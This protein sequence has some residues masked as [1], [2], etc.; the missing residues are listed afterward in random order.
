MSDP[1][2]KPVWGVYGGS[3][4]GSSHLRSGLPNQDS[5]GKWADPGGSL[6][7]LAVSDGHGSASHFRSEI[8]SRMGVEAAVQ[9]LRATPIPVPDGHAQVL[10]QSIVQ[11]WREAV[12]AHLA[13]HPFTDGEWGKLPPKESAQA[14][15]AILANPP[16]AYGATLLAV[17]A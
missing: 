13:G 11:A 16:V 1:S 8:G 4:R 3:T 14:K 10:A 6:A 9:A 17:L 12:M 2:G 15:A 7:I 5:I